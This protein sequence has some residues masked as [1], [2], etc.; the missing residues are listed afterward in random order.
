VSSANF[1]EKYPTSLLDALSSIGGILGLINIGF[2]L[3]WLHANRFEERLQDMVDSS[4]Q[5]LEREDDKK[6]EDE[7]FDEELGESSR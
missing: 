5:D 6:F 2:F 3:E 1:Y 7:L 4:Q